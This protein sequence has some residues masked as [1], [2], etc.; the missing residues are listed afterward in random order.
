M[1]PSTGDSIEEVLQALAGYT[2]GGDQNGGGSLGGGGD[3][4]AA[5]APVIS[6]QLRPTVAKGAQGAR[7]VWME[8]RH[9]K[10]SMTW[11]P[12]A[13]P[14]KVIFWRIRAY[15]VFAFK[16]EWVVV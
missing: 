16:V 7:W 12:P 13:E 3:G 9:E 15:Y 14:G 6:S 1:A 5:T 4:A 2:I 10:P 11:T 8:S